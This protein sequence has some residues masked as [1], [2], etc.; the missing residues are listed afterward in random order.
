[1]DGFLFKR[2]RRVPLGESANVPASA[3]K[4]KT[5][6]KPEDGQMLEEDSVQPGPKGPAP[7]V[8]CPQTPLTVP[9]SCTLC[10][11][12]KDLAPLI[13]I[14]VLFSRWYLSGRDWWGRYKS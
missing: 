8:C 6:Q 11:P 12:I 1:M 7:D 3:K 9:L 13:L 14:E 4:A 2:K 10:L 5:Q